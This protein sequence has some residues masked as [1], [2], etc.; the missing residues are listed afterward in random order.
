MA[1]TKPI[2]PEMR[3]R[4]IAA[5][6]EAWEAGCPVADW[7]PE[8]QAKT[9]ELALRRLG[10]QRRRGVSPDDREAQVA[11]LARGLIEASEPGV[12]TV[13][14]LARDY[15][16]LAELVLTAITSVGSEPNSND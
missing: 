2:P 5:V 11:D 13:G 8:G 3:Q 14:A 16:W 9:A 15:E 7:R 1:K 4:V 10:S 6:A 12:E